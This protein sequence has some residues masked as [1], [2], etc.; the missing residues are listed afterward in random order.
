MV[1]RRVRPRSTSRELASAPLKAATDRG[2]RAIERV[3]A[4][5][6][7]CIADMGY[8][9]ASSNQIAT[10]AGVSWGVI[11]HHFGTRQAILLALMDE[12]IQEIETHWS[13]QPVLG[14]VISEKLE[15][16]AT[17]IWSYYTDSNHLVFHEIYINLTR[18][19]DTTAEV[20][21]RLRQ[22]E[23]RAFKAWTALMRPILDEVDDG[24]VLQRLLLQS[25]WG[26]VLNRLVK[27]TDDDCGNERALLI[28]ALGRYFERPRPVK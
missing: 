1:N 7:L 16:V 23:R 5:A 15:S 6:R 8:A 25:L 17:T 13:R 26:L 28:A 21:K 10:H 14:E 4:A 20:K 12:S 9:R 24:A 22:L 19:P 2:A 11:Q 18:D 3:L 27:G